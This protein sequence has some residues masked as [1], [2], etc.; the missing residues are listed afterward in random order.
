[1]DMTSLEVLSDQEL[2]SQWREGQDSAFELIITRY[3]SLIYR[4][5]LALTKETA[6]AE[7]VLARVFTDAHSRLL[8]SFTEVR[9]LERYLLCSTLQHSQAL[10]DRWQ[11]AI[12]DEESHLKSLNAPCF[13]EDE[14][15]DSGCLDSDPQSADSSNELQIEYVQVD[16]NFQFADNSR[17]SPL[18][19]WHHSKLRASLPPVLDVIPEDYRQAFILHDVA[20]LS[21]GM[22]AKILGR[23]I[24]DITR[25]LSR[26]R[27]T[28]RAFLRQPEAFQM[29]L[30]L[31]DRGLTRST[32]HYDA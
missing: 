13:S 6:I 31:H 27:L 10:I 26:T 14:V 7:E 4:V 22:I 29:S 20:G 9:D 28:M 16:F 1:M 12:S 17:I 5:A 30:P 19:H 25:L 18:H 32:R 24:P 15:H 8:N 3:E 2:I 23:A 21:K 11:N